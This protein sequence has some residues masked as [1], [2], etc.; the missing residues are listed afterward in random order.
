LAAVVGVPGL[1]ASLSVSAAEP[2]VLRVVVV[3]TA[4]IPTYVRELETL[5][6]LYKKKATL[7]ERAIR[8]NWEPA[9]GYAAGPRLCNAT[10][11]GRRRA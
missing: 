11:P 9:A 3:Q 8:V 7:A 6:A 4:D 10:E 5:K 1:T 2:A